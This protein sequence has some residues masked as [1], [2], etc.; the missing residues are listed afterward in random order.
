[1]HGKTVVII[2]GG[3]AGLMAADVLSAAGTVVTVYE[4]MPTVARKFLMAG[5]SGLNITH[6]EDYG[7]F[8]SRFGPAQAKLQAALDDFTPAMLRDW[9]LSLGQ[10]TFTGTSGR[11]FPVAM[12][13]SPLLRAWLSRLNAQGVEI[14][15]RHRWAGFDGN[16]LLFQTP[17]GDVTVQ[18]GTVLL[19]IGGASWPKL[20]SDAAWVPWLRQKGVAIND[21]Q[22]ANCGFDVE[23]SDHFRERF[24]GAPV[25][26]VV[27]TSQ[28]GRF[29][30]EFVITRHGIEGSLVYAHSA[31]LRDSFQQTDRPALI[32]DLAPGRTQQR[33]TH[34]LER[35]PRKDSLSNRL[36]KAAGLSPVK[37]ALLREC[38]PDLPAMSAAEIAALI[39]ALPVSVTS[40]RP[41]AEAISSAGGIDREEIDQHYMLKSMPGTFTAG[42][43]LDWEAPT[44]G[45][46]LTACFATGKAAA[47]GIIHRLDHDR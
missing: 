1:M 44:G 4:A 39:K 7:D 13:A 28:A 21:F 20:G 26:S 45:Y 40:P 38:R 46:L 41:I 6:A 11:V 34:D 29:E 14:K 2:G 27:T 17:S 12:K 16:A 33:L 31:A 15:T 5:K 8:V 42:E 3:P 9:A 18:Q 35:H 25:K 23:W 30:G 10:E 37:V 22:P 43:M 24:A 32:V 36:R 47:R 19:A